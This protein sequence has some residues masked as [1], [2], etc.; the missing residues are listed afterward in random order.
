MVLI[1]LETST[2]KRWCSRC[3]EEIPA[4][5]F[6]LVVIQTSVLWRRANICQSCSTKIN[7]LL[8]AANRRRK[9]YEKS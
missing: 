2:R 8:K 4:R 5:T 1:D 6:M 3:K 9:G 7:T